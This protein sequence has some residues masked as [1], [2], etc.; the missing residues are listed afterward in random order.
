MHFYSV[1]RDASPPRNGF[2]KYETT[3]RFASATEQPGL[4]SFHGWYSPRFNDYIVKSDDTWLEGTRLGYECVGIA[5]WAY[6]QPTEGTVK[7]R[8]LLSRFRVENFQT[9]WDEEADGLLSSGNWDE[10]TSNCFVRKSQSS[11]ALPIH[12]WCSEQGS[13][14][15]ALIGKEGRN[16]LEFELVGED[17]F[18]IEPEAQ[19]KLKSYNEKAVA[20]DKAFAL[21]FEPFWEE[22]RHVPLVNIRRKLL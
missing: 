12:R 10:V 9:G 21:S 22:E 17:Q 3:S 8:H 14:K 2:F 19:S 11:A 1:D 18:S 20:K 5:F 15:V 13:W 7:L 4:S 16:L 6:S